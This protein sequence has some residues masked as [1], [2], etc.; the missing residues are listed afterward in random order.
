MIEFKKLTEKANK[1]LDAMEKEGE[2]T[3]DEKKAVIDALK[4]FRFY[5]GSWTSF[6]N[7]GKLMGRLMEDFCNGMD[8]D[9]IEGFCKYMTEDTHRTLQQIFFNVVLQYIKTYAEYKYD[10]QRNA[11]SHHKAKVILNF[12]EEN[13]IALRSPLI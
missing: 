1:A 2:L 8:K 11:S 4:E 5:M 9:D 7:N 3:Q 6:A 12:L 10:D 13:G